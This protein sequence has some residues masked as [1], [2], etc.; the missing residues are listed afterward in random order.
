MDIKDFYLNTPMER[1][2]YMRIPIDIIPANIFE[3]YNL[4][5]LVHNGT[6]TVE[7]RKGMYGLSNAGRLASNTTNKSD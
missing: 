1:Y 5:K 7:I 4:E 2:E 3:Y 6:V